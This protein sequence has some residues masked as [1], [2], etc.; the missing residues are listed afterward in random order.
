MSDY[1][2]VL[3][4]GCALILWAGC[5]FFALSRLIKRSSA[6]SSARA[7]ARLGEMFIFV[8]GER[9][10]PLKIAL[11]G[12]GAVIGIW[13]GAVRGWWMLIFLALIGG[14]VGFYLPDIFL[15]FLWQRR[16]RLFSSQLMDALILLASGLRAGFSLTQTL[17]LLVEES[18]P[19]LSQEMALVLREYR[20]GVDLET[21]LGNCARRMAD[22]DL[23]L[24]VSAV[25]IT[26]QIGGN[27][28]VIFDRMEALI[29]ERLMLKG[30]MDAL[31]S[32]GRMQAWVIGLMPYFFAAALLKVNPAM[33]QVL[34]TTPVG[35][36]A[37]VVI[38]VL[39][40]LGFLW[41]RRI[42]TLRF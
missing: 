16:R 33:L 13:I 22:G 38:F 37:L 4:F 40:L 39:D 21:A 20:V 41:V 8:P 6:Q 25:A 26:R 5:F 11:L 23:Q 1:L 42:A 32:Q 2:V 17:E 34:W 31:T 7:N 29:R 27:L 9:F 15:A 14:S 12:V 3:L 19:P 36:V 30:K 18:R 24:V 28:A 10:W 35:F